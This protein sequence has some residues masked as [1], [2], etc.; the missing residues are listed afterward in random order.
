MMGGALLQ[1]A[2][3]QKEKA[4]SNLIHFFLTDNDQFKTK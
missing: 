2:I 1:P 3:L 4:F